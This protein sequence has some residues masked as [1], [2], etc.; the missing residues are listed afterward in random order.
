MMS[1]KRIVLNLARTLSCVIS[2]LDIFF[3][4]VSYLNWNVNK[5]TE[6]DIITKSTTNNDLA[7]SMVRLD[8][9]YSIAWVVQCELITSLF[10][11]SYSSSAI[12][13]LHDGEITDMMREMRRGLCVLAAFWSLIDPFLPFI[14]LNLVM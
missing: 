3:L 1:S 9:R 2:F 13:H 10:V 4:S 11:C 14:F 8:I 5:L 12:V 6:A 7:T